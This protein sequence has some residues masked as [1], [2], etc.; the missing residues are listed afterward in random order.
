M[1]KGFSPTVASSKIQ[2]HVLMTFLRAARRRRRRLLACSRH[3]ASRGEEPAAVPALESG[4]ITYNPRSRRSLARI[5]RPPPICTDADPHPRLLALH[6]A[7]HPSVRLLRL[8]RVEQP[9]C[10]LAGSAILS[11]WV[12]LYKCERSASHC[13]YIC[14]N[15]VTP[16][17]FAQ[18]PD[19][20]IQQR[21]H[22]SV[23]LVIPD[24]DANIA[25]GNFMASLVLSAPGNKSLV[26]VSRPVSTT[27]HRRP[28]AAP[29]YQGR[30]L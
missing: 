27:I 12:S 11:I 17:A 21:Y 25:L 10:E 6:P 3:V 16:H 9:L 1:V 14:R 15:G 29:T 4:H 19:I 30:R 26:S 7:H 18:L 28:F 24:S 13:F 22:I 5:L 8:V 20:N 23:N 2:Y